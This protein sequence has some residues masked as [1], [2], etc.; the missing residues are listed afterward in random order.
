[1]YLDFNNGQVAISETVSVGT[2]YNKYIVSHFGN[3]KIKKIHTV[4]GAGTQKA[5]V[6]IKKNIN[7]QSLWETTLTNME[8]NKMV[9]IDC[10]YELDGEGFFLGYTAT[11]NFQSAEVFFTENTVGDNTLIVGDGRQWQDFLLH[12][13]SFQLV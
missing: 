12:G 10:D 4:F 8:T 3:N 1:M 5:T 6:W 2:Y 13:L 9:S 7:G 11:G